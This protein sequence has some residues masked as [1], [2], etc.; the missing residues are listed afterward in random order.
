MLNQKQKKSGR[1]AFAITENRK[2]QA[3]NLALNQRDRFD[4]CNLDQQRIIRTQFSNQLGGNKSSFYNALNRVN[5]PVSEVVFWCQIFDCRL[6]DLLKEPI[7]KI[8]SVKEL[9]RKVDNPSFKQGQ[10]DI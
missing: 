7:N 8:P 4:K 10:L 3:S 9:E 2:K 5:P 6:Q 1:K